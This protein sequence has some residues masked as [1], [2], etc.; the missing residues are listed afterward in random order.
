MNTFAPWFREP[1]QRAS[2]P[3]ERTGY[4]RAVVTRRKERRTGPGSQ[5]HRGGRP[6]AETTR[7]AVMLHTS[8]LTVELG[9]H[10]VLRDVELT[11][12]TG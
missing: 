9:R 2:G 3:R 5:R 6:A 11:L 10:Q 12:Q 1:N 4:R 7:E 8:G